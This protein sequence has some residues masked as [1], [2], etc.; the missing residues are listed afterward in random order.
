MPPAGSAGLLA[1]IG[2]LSDLH[3]RR[4]THLLREA[5]DRLAELDCDLVVITGDLSNSHRSWRTT[6]KQLRD[7]LTGL[8]EH[9]PILAV[10]GNHDN[11]RLGVAR[12]LP[13]TFLDHEWQSVPVTGGNLRVAGLPQSSRNRGELA[14]ALP[15]RAPAEEPILLLAHYPSTVYALPDRRVALQLSGHTHGGQ[16]RL[17]RL[18]CVLNRDRFPRH[19]SQGLHRVN[20]TWV[21]VTAGVG[22]TGPLPLRWNCPPEV[23]LVTVTRQPTGSVTD[24]EEEEPDDPVAVMCESACQA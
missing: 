4:S 7:C 17:P 14:S 1:R 11:A 2:H 3:L 10:L 18:G 6:A 9:T 24:L 5:A 16:I 22:C 15:P 8:A 19:A 21:H 20:G 12:D 13:V 23:G